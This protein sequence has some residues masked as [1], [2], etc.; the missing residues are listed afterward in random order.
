MKLV[1]HQGSMPR[2]RSPRPGR[3][4]HRPARGA[5]GRDLS[6]RL[7]AQPLTNSRCRAPAF[8]R[9]AEG[10]L[11]RVSLAIAVVLAAVWLYVREPSRRVSRRALG[12]RPGRARRRIPTARGPQAVPALVALG[13]ARPADQAHVRRRAARRGR[14][15]A[16][17]GQPARGQREHEHQR[18][19]AAFAAALRHAAGAA[20]AGHHRERPRHRARRRRLYGHLDRRRRARLLGQAV[21]VVRRP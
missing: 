14:A 2:R 17:A 21:L 18:G 6:R 10:M 1:E 16:L 4:Q 3:R 7:A 5:R 12:G 11:S 8:V 20:L 19:H 15:S 9:L 13:R